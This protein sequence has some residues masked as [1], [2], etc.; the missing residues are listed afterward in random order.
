MF[1]SGT[2]QNL[3][4]NG[5]IQH[6]MAA[7][8]RCLDVLLQILSNVTNWGVEKHSKSTEVMLELSHLFYTDKYIPSQTAKDDMECY[9]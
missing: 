7:P 2:Q 8:R 6:K 3:A 5:I 1:S 4:A 9:S